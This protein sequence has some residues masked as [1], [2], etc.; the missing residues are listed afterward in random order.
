MG[1]PGRD[2]AIDD[3]ARGLLYPFKPYFGIGCVEEAGVGRS[4]E[5]AGE[6]P[7]VPANVP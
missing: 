1:G 7:G 4:M 2:A 3:A 6:L 5:D